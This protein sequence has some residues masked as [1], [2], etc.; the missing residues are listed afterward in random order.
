M[1]QSY[2]KA[3]LMAV[4]AAECQYFSALIMS[5]ECHLTALF[6]VTKSFL[7]KE[8]SDKH[9]QSHMEEF[10][11]NLMYKIVQI[12]FWLDSKCPLENPR[13]RTYP[14]AVLSHWT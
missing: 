11:E 4:R 9:L 8:G 2:I 7:R 13:D 5:T 10:V 12:H 1:C 14:G 3:Y 6:K